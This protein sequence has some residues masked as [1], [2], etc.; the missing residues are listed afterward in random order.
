M[1][2]SVDLKMWKF[3]SRGGCWN[4]S[5]LLRKVSRL[6]ALFPCRG[7]PKTGFNQNISLI[8]CW[9]DSKKRQRP[10]SDSPVMQAWRSS[11]GCWNQS[12]P[13]RAFND[14][15]WVQ[16]ECSTKGHGNWSRHSAYIYESLVQKK[17]AAAQS[18]PTLSSLP[19]QGRAH[20]GFRA[21]KKHLP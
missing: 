21:K 15:P 11:N 12:R 8:Q 20:A 4:W 17:V 16:T 10:I 9:R 18:L 13:R 7:V 1:G 19:L 5:L 6:W 14:R 2:Q 3:R